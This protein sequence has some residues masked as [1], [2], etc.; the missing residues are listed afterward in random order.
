M[1]N[2][3]DGMTPLDFQERMN[4]KEL[5]ELLRI[6]KLKKFNL[7]EPNPWTWQV[8]T[9]LQHEKD[10]LKQI[11]SVNHPNLHG[12]GHSHGHSHAHAPPSACHDHSHGSYDEHN[13]QHAYATSSSH[14]FESPNACEFENSNEQSSPNQMSQNVNNS[15]LVNPT[16]N[17]I[18]N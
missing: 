5:Q 9:K 2:L 10:T 8:W 4:S 7:K 1:K 11:I 18:L 13:A 16:S 6:H 14:P 17:C 12:H 3:K 15:D